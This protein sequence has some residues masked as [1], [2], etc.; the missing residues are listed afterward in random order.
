MPLLWASGVEGIWDYL[1]IDLLGPSLDNLLRN[2]G[3]DSMDLASVSTIAMQV[4]RILRFSF[5][6]SISI[7]DIDIK[8]RI[9]AL[10]WHFTS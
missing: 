10:T 2:S 7:L 5:T 9:H 4:V 6:R 1:V 8:T 3:K